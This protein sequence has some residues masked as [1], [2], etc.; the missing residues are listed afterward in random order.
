MK[1]NNLFL[2]SLSRESRSSLV[3]LCAEVDLPL[4]KMLYEPGVVPQYAF[5]MTSGIAS[6]VAM[7]ENGGMAE[8]GL[9]GREGVVGS[10]HLLGPAKVSTSCF[11]QLEATALRIRFA[12]LAMIFR[13]NE[14]V[15]ERLLEFVQEQAVSLSQLAGCNRLHDNEQR[16]ARW[17]LTAQDRAGTDTLHF[18]Q[19]FLA[20]MLGARRTTVTLIAG[21]LQRQG[22]IQYQRGRVKILKRAELEAASCDCYQITKELYSSLYRNALYTAEEA[23]ETSAVPVKVGVAEKAGLAMGNGGGAVAT[24]G[25]IAVAGSAKSGSGNGRGAVAKKGSARSKR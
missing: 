1:H 21:A 22:L 16:L 24:S 5:F 23:A 15:R 2:E 11:I 9:I 14:E 13:T 4:K 6:V 12:D 17:L 3:R 10:F 19:E 18:T 8:V 20:M 7:M 25:H